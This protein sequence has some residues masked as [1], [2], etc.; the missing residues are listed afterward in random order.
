MRGEIV[1]LAEVVMG[2]ELSEGGEGR[3]KG[4]ETRA[5]ETARQCQKC[6]T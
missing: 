4:S 6:E 2:L 1:K 3:S 5:S